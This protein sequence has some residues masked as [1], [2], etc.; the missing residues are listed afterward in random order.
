MKSTVL[1]A[2]RTLLILT[3]LTGLAY[4]LAV[5]ALAQGLF[6]TQA[7]G[8]LIQVRGAPAGVAPLGSRLIGQPFS[9]DRYLWGRPSATAPFAYNAAASTGSNLGPSNP[10]L[11]DAVRGRVAHLRAT[12]PQAQGP[13][14]TD[15]VTTSG[16]GLDPHISVAA[17]QFQAPRLALTRHLSAAKINA[18]LASC[19]EPPFLGML[20]PARVHVLCVN[21][22]LD[23]LPTEP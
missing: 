16:S 7:N 14:P 12:N 11:T 8:S 19:T 1:I 10:A 18:L 20:G 17:A 3:A 22:A 23:D 9:G 5:T 13:V 2:L 15:L 4:P 21:A 6:P